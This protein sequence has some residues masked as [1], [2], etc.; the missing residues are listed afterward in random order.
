MSWLPYPVVLLAIVL[1][2]AAA[3]RILGRRQR[4]GDESDYVIRARLADPYE[5]RLFVRVPFMAWLA[6]RAHRLGADPERALRAAGS[7]ASGASVLITMA[8]A[9][10]LAGAQVA[11]AIGLLLA[12][13]P[14]RAVL[15][16]HIWPDNWLAL[17]LA[18]VCLLVIVPGPSPDLR[19]ALVGVVAA[20]AFLT[21]LDAVLLGPFVAI[22]LAPVSARQWLL[23]VLPTALTFAA[24]TLR[25]ARRYG[26]LWPDN[27][28]MFNVM[29]AGGEAQRRR[30]VR[31][32][33]D[34]EVQR[35][36]AEWH[37]LTDRQ[38]FAR[39]M[40][41]LRVLS[42]RPLRALGDVLARL[43]ASF[44]PDSFAMDRL[45]PPH[46]S[47]YPEINAP[48]TRLLRIALTVAFPVLVSVAILIVAVGRPP[49]AWI[50]W[51]TL[52]MMV[53]SLIHNRT[54]YRQAWLPGAALLVAAAMA[55]PEF[56]PA[57]FSADSL[58]AW[59]LS[60]VVGVALARFRIR[61][62]IRGE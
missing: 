28:W 55:D 27:T 52:A 33:V 58:P 45:L 39:A 30:S 50:L 13:L 17:W 47:A 40:S 48:A 15:S 46:G 42:K 3:G 21:R 44:G 61:A 62:D 37:G 11:L 49:P 10:I 36:L 4:V 19:A 16:G 22:G 34:Q 14:D 60:A 9:H 31:M 35:V 32:L 5:P 43:W 1:V 41:G 53:G 25:N 20:L 24:L 23:M 29:V 54:R 51:P 6:A 59:I 56:W 8:S 7:A 18:L 2:H 26:I 57:L 38:R 12:L